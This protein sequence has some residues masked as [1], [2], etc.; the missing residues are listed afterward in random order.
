MSLPAGG[1]GCHP[2]RTVALLRSI[3]EAAQ[4][5]LSVIAGVRDDIGPE[6]Y[7]RSDDPALLEAWWSGAIALN[8][9]RRFDESPNCEISGSEAEAGFLLSRLAMAGLGEVIS[10]DLSPKECDAIRVA[11]MIVPG[12][13][14]PT[15]AGCLRGKRAVSVREHRQ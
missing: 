2:S 3:T 9:H 4:A 15:E 14:P 5:R 6:M 10:V 11:R 12:L 1:E 13:E 7:G 8:G